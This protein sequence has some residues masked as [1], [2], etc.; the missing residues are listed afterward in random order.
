MNIYE[1]ESG[2]DID[3]AI[4]ELK[5]SG[6]IT[7]ESAR[8]ATVAAINTAAL[9][10]IAGSL[11]V[12]AAEAEAAMSV[13]EGAAEVAPEDRDFLIEGDLVAVAGL[14][15]P[16]EVVSFGVS[17]GAFYAIVRL[18]D[19]SESRAWLD[20]L[21]RLVGDDRDDDAMQD[22]SEAEVEDTLGHG[23][24]DDIGLPIPDL[25]DDIDD[26]FESDEHPAA[27]SALDLLKSN[28]A[29]RKAGK[30]KGKKS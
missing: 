4:V 6:S 26:D 9:L 29:A 15:D 5:R 25:V 3:A 10:D 28:E 14:D 16:A 30:K 7:G 19:G 20:T 11:R 17:E 2:L 13:A 12:I 22:A 24:L 21:T 1:N 18:T 8:K 27:A 23:K